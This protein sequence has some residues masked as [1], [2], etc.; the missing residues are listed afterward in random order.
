MRGCPAQA[1]NGTQGSPSV[2]DVTARARSVQI[3]ETVSHSLQLLGR[4]SAQ[5][6]SSPTIS[7]GC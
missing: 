4:M 1:A 2:D 6:T 7:R 5:S 3:G